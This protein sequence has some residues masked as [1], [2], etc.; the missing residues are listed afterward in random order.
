MSLLAGLGA[1]G[2]GTLVARVGGEDHPAGM[3]YLRRRSRSSRRL[4]GA[5]RP[6]RTRPLVHPQ[7]AVAALGRAPR[8]A[9]RGVRLG[10]VFLVAL[11]V[12]Q[13][14]CSCSSPLLR[15]RGRSVDDLG[16]RR[17]P[18][19]DPVRGA[20]RGSR[21]LDQLAPVPNEGTLVFSLTA[22]ALSRARWLF[23]SGDQRTEGTRSTTGTSP[24]AERLRSPR[25]PDRIVFAALIGTAF[26]SRQFPPT[27]SG[28]LDA[29]GPVPWI[30]CHG[31]SDDRPRRAE[32]GEARR[33]CRGPSI[34]ARSSSDTSSSCSRS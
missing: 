23:A 16:S 4:V 27:C 31:G 20:R 22:M 11:P 7:H 24:D 2:G 29:E 32:V 8:R 33:G 28:H 15:A 12:G 10:A 17:R 34:R 6:G 18:R 9:A 13:Q 3:A 14:L 1:V 25:A 19:R 30:R 26:I 21:P 5:R